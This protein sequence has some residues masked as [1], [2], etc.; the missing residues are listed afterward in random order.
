MSLLIFLHPH[1]PFPSWHENV[2]HVLHKIVMN[3]KKK[4]TFIYGLH[5]ND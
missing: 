2:L 4:L 1:V 3:V 5:S